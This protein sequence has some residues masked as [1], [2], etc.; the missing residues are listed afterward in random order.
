[1]RW[2]LLVGAV[3]LAGC[4]DLLDLHGVERETDSDHDGVPD[5]HDNCPVIPNADQ[6]DVDHDGVGDACDTGTIASYDEDSDGV[7]DQDDNCPALANVDQ[8]DADGDAVGDACDLAASTQ[9]RVVFD[10]FNGTM[11]GASWQVSGDPWS[12]A[13]GMASPDLPLVASPILVYPGLDLH[14]SDTGSWSLSLGIVVPTQPLDPAT[15]QKIGGDLLMGQ[16]TWTCGVVYDAAV[17]EWH[18]E[19]ILPLGVGG[20]Q[21]DPVVGPTVIA[22]GSTVQLRASFLASSPTTTA[23]IQCDVR[24]GDSIS[25]RNVALSAQLLLVID[26]EGGAL[27]YVDFV[28]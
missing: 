10:G 27:T 17:G 13:N 9:H 8:A 16:K 5:Q 19:I 11:L 1:M 2:R 22:P 20:T 23:G 4:N 7:L 6:A 12:V 3:L 26:A 14:G 21:V 15:D 18:V 28:N 25:A 24:G